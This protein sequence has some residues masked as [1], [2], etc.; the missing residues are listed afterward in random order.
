MYFSFF[1]LGLPN[2]GDQQ[3]IREKIETYIGRAEILKGKLDEKKKM[4]NYHEQIE[5]E[6]NAKGFTYERVFGRLLDENVEQIDITDPYIHNT[7]QVK[8]NFLIL[9]LNNSVFMMGISI[10]YFAY[11][12]Q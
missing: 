2:K 8:P 9:M 10:Y 5:I 12:L 7:C 11:I 3:K 1:S 6:N 4:G